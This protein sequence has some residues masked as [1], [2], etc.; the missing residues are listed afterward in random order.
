MK[1]FTNIMLFLD[2]GKQCTIAGFGK[3][4][5][6]FL[7]SGKVINFTGFGTTPARYEDEHFE[8]APLRLMSFSETFG[9]MHYDCSNSICLTFLTFVLVRIYAVQITEV[10]RKS[11]LLNFLDIVY[12]PDLDKPKSTDSDVE[13]NVS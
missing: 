13:G 9:N 3:I 11:F 2:T 6:E 7:K 4:F 1:R 5:D 12:N 10:R 8:E